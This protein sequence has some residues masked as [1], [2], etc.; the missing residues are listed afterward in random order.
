MNVIVSLNLPPGVEEQLRATTPDLSAA[1]REAYTIDLFRK[2][3][4]THYELGQALGLDRFETDALLKRH[5]VTEHSL[6]HEDVEADV[7]SINELLGPP[8]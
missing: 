7:R 8:R 5:Q 2:G 6:T 1:V 4:L 3:V